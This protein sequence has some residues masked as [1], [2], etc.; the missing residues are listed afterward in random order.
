MERRR[1]GGE[2]GR[3]RQKEGKDRGGRVGKTHLMEGLGSVPRAPF[4]GS[5]EK[6]DRQS[7]HV[8]QQLG[9]AGALRASP[10]YR[11]TQG[12]DGMRGSGSTW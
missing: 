7:L 3:E 6:T 4:C 9:R 11:T 12:E 2:R 1:E 10:Q 5:A 8:C